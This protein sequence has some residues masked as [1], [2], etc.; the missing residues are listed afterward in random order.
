MKK[1]KLLVFCLALL[2]FIMLMVPVAA[3]ATTVGVGPGD[4]FKYGVTA[5][6]NSTM[7]PSGFEQFAGLQ[8]VKV[9][10]TAVSGTEIA[11]R[12]TWHYQNGS[13]TTDSGQVDVKTGAG[14]LTDSF[15]AANLGAGDTTYTN[16]NV[17]IITSTTARTYLGHMIE[18][19]YAQGQDGPDFYWAQ[20]TGAMVEMNYN[21]TILQGA[22]TVIVSVHVTIVDS[23]TE[24][25]PEFPLLMLPAVFA[26]LTLAAVILRRKSKTTHVLS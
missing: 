11:G 14:N 18:T 20:S 21:T 13:E 15:I 16:T 9:L 4:W 3:Q 25:V 17:N 5:S 24:V 7:P 19:N 26:A 2:P 12:A 1:L 8:W 22:D 10:V 23:G 6:W